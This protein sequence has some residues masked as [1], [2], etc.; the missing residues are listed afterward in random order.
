MVLAI[1]GKYPRSVDD[2]KAQGMYVEY[3]VRVRITE[4]QWIFVVE[5]VNDRME[6]CESPNLL[7][8]YR[9]TVFKS[10]MQC[11]L[12]C[13][14]GALGLIGVWMG[15]RSLEDHHADA[16]GGAE[17][18]QVANGTASSTALSVVL[19]I[20]GLSVAAV[21]AVMGMT[22]WECY[23]WKEEG[24]VKWFYWLLVVLTYIQ[25]G[26]YIGLC[27]KTIRRFRWAASG[28]GGPG[29]TAGKEVEYAV[30]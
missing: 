30:A 3:C 16:R 27:W 20:L 14:G 2:M 7:S 29:Q 19:A 17:G 25:L 12:Y 21:L 15:N 23:K 9:Y 5:W 1:V 8:H 10:S 11:A 4:G 24:A 26:S 18:T 22:G 13:M 28:K 6:G